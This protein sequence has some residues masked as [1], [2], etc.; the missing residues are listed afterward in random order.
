MSNHAHS[1]EPAGEQAPRVPWREAEAGDAAR[2]DPMNPKPPVSGRTLYLRRL[3]RGDLSRT[4]AWLH[5]PDVHSKIGV[6]IP[7]TREQQ[8]QWFRRLQRDESKV[9]FAVCR[10]AD[11]AHIGNVSLDLIDRRHRNARLSIFIGDQ[12]ARGKGL[13]SEALRLL[14]QYARDELGLHK[15]WCKTDAGYPEVMKFYR[16]LGYAREGLLRE[17]EVKNHVYVDKVLLGKLL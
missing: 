15:I 1:A 10:K 4:R 7:F 5:R 9:V 8:L 3:E 11:D 16:R 6:R 13:G 17:H 14:E 12:S 2:V